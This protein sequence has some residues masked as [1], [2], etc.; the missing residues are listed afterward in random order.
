MSSAV[1]TQRH[2]PRESQALGATTRFVL[3]LVFALAVPASGC[4]R[5]EARGIA[6][7]AGGEDRASDF[8]GRAIDGS[9]VRLSD[10]LGKQAVL[11]YFCT[12][13]YHSCLAEVVHVRRIYD[14]ER[15]RGF[16]VIA[17]AM[18]SPN[19]VAEVPAWARRNDLVFPVVLDE[20]SHIASVYNPKKA[21][22]FT[23]LIDKKGDIAYVHDG[24]SPGDEVFLER[25]IASVLES[26]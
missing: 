13:W 16:V 15:S 2:K 5:V 11:L 17:I 9:T 20:D 26:P 6:P 18:D 8:T 12:T 19:T 3:T 23:V 25:H 1:P 10:Y 22:P 4:G 24:Y 7:R 21:A 14:K